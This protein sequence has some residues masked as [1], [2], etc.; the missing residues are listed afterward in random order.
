[1]ALTCANSWSALRVVNTTHD[2]LYAEFRP[3]N[4]APV[5]RSS[6]NFTFAC[7][8]TNDPYQLV[9][10]ARLWPADVLRQWSDELWA[11]ATCA[12]AQCP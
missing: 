11:V 5:A 1:M 4:R 9:N 3:T 2:V 10:A 6:T 8:M 7:N 12:G